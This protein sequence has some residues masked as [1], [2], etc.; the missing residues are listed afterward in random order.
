MQKFCILRQNGCKLRRK[1]FYGTGPCPPPFLTNVVPTVPKASTNAQKEWFWRENLNV[2]FKSI[3]S[4]QYCII[5]KTN[6]KLTYLLAEIGI[7]AV[8]GWHAGSE[9]APEDR[10]FEYP[11][12]VGEDNGMSRVL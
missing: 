1:K 6:L 9:F 2:Y 3:F 11:T 12:S 4:S 5:F 10:G 7:G 8:A